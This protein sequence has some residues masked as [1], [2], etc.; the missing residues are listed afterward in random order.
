MNSIVKP[1]VYHPRAIK[2]PDTTLPGEGF[3]LL[4]LAER[5]WAGDLPG[6]VGRTGGG[7]AWRLWMG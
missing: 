7:N 5:Q 3:D 4:H 2:L 6:L 1:T